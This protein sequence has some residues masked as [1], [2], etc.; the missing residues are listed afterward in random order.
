MQVQHIL[1]NVMGSLIRLDNVS[2][3]IFVFSEFK[4]TLVITNINSHLIFFFFYVLMNNILLLL[5]F[6][7]YYY[8]KKYFIICFFY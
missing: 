6:K 2:T 4:R 1:H 3:K 5:D 8:V 7:Q